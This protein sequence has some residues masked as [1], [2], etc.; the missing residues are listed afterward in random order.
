[1]VVLS[2]LLQLGWDSG[3]LVWARGAQSDRELG[4][5]L[6]QQVQSVQVELEEWFGSERLCCQTV[7]VS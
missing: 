3:L 1:M 4:A 5:R 2:E 7:V 6:V